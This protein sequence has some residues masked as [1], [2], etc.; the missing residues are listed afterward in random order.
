MTSTEQWFD[1]SDNI[2]RLEDFQRTPPLK[3]NQLSR[4][5]LAINHHYFIFLWRGF[6]S[7]DSTVKKTMLFLNTVLRTKSRDN[8]TSVFLLKESIRRS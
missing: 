5:E 1:I 6:H 2:S 7:A 4:N 3:R 8:N